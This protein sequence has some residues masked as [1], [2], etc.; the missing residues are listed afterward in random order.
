MKHLFKKKWKA[1]IGVP[2]FALSTL[3]LPLIASAQTQITIA[4][5]VPGS[6]GAA[7]ASGAPGAFIADFY[8]FALI[9]GGIL[10]FG[11]IVYG[12]VKYMASVG[13]PSGQSDAKEWIESALLGLLLLVGVYFILSVI[14]PQ[15]LNLNLPSLVPVNLSS[16]VVPGNPPGTPSGPATP[17]QACSTLTSAGVKVSCSQLNGVQNATVDALSDLE[18]ECPGASVSVTSVTGGQHSVQG[19]CTHANG[20]KADVAPSAALNSCV[21]GFTPD[22]IRSD[23]APLYIAPDGAIFANEGARPSNCGKNCNWT[24]GHWDIQACGV[25]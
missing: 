24:G 22:G 6:Y 14:N 17:S 11:I 8:W 9:V 7:S 15:L 21:Q 23:G 16:V 5:S 20:Y 1:L 4:S 13:N 3:I 19:G 10:V 25:R 2:V 12:G 18:K